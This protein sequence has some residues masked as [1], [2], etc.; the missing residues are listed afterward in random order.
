MIAVLTA[1]LVNST[2]FDNEQ[3]ASWLTALCQKLGND[4]SFD[5]KLKPEI[6]RGDSFQAALSQ[7][8]HSLRAAILARA[9]IRQRSPKTDLRIAIGIGEAERI[10]D[11][12]GTSDGEAFRLSGRLAD[13]MR[14]L[15]NRIAFAIPKE[16]VTLDAQMALLEVLM[17]DRT[18]AQYEVIEGLLNGETISQMANR[19]SVSQPAISQ[20]VSAAKWWAIESVLNSFPEHLALYKSL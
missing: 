4:R 13:R 20:R 16:S 19:L 18:T 14:G 8:E 1:D 15:Q 7:P 11:R 12:P 2:H 10:T 17:E 3:T 9:W 6:Y 5:W